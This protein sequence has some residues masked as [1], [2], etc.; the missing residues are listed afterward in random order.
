MNRLINS[1]SIFDCDEKEEEIH[2]I[3]IENFF[4][5]LQQY[6]NYD[7]AAIFKYFDPVNKNQEP[8]IKECSLHECEDMIEYVDIKNGI[9][10][11]IVKEYLTIV[12]YGQVYT[13]QGHDFI[14]QVGIQIRPYDKERN[15]INLFAN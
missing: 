11:M 12:A 7:C 14:T 8:I 1:K 9:D 6:P 13:Y 15:F 3:E 2:N 5:K 10:L 4:E